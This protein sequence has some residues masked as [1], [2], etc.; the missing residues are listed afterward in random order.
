MEEQKVVLRIADGRLVKG[1]LHD[2]SPSGEGV[3]MEDESGAR[4]RFDMN[5]LKAI[6]FVRTFEG[7]KSRHEKKSF[8]KEN[9]PGK[10]VFVKFKDGESMVG[11]VEGEVPWQ[12]GFFLEPAKGKGFFLLPTDDESNNTKVFV[13]AQSVWEVTVMG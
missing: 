8:E 12:K 7:D 11:Y 4:Q 6:F 9:P 13:I 3:V 1:H 2:F 10:R 5:E